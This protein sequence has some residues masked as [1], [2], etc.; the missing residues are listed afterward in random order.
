MRR[1]TPQAGPAGKPTVSVGTSC[2][3]PWG[4]GTPHVSFGARQA[5]P[6]TRFWVYLFPGS[7]W[8]PAAPRRVSRGSGSQNGGAG[9]VGPLERHPAPRPRHP[10]GKRRPGVDMTVAAGVERDDA[11]RLLA[12]VLH[13]Q[14]VVAA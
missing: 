4:R 5:P 7:W 1:R 9:A 3:S 11:G 10:R 14:L 6:A 12:A 8:G 2:T 13:P